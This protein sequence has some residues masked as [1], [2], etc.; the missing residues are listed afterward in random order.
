MSDSI[1]IFQALKNLRKIKRDH[2]G[3]KCPVCI[4]RLPRANPKVLLPR[5]VCRAHKPHYQDPRPE[6]EQA[7]YDTLPQFSQKDT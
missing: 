7:D 5:Q 3:V 1:E 2:F 4:E 6:L